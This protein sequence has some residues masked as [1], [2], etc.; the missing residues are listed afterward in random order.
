MSKEN[1]EGRFWYNNE[2]PI[3]FIISDEMINASAD[4]YTI[5]NVDK[6]QHSTEEIIQKIKYEPVDAVYTDIVNFDLFRAVIIAGAVLYIPEE[7]EGM[8]TWRLHKFGRT[9]HSIGGTKKNIGYQKAKRA[10]DIAGGCVGLSL[11]LASYPLVSRA[12]KKEDGGPVIYKQHR[13]GYNGREF[14]MY[15]YRS[16]RV[17][18]DEEKQKLAEQNQMQGKYMFKM[19]NDPRITKVGKFIRKTSI[20]ELPQFVNVIRGEM[21]LVGTRPPIDNEVSNYKARHKARLSAKPG[22][23]GV[24][25]TQGRNKISNFEDVV[26]LDKKYIMQESITEDLCII[27]KTVLAVF[28]K[29][30]E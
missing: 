25:Q 2:K 26:G 21:S 13:I 9:V 16:M 1:L 20:D 30:G 3:L 27:A 17:D 23:T 5:V 22:I 7:V 14:E 28:H 10:M 8:K 29:E 12:I 4:D 15:K 11:Y 6:S 24:W 18:A 19:D